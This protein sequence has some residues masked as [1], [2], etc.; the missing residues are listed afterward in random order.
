MGYNEGFRDYDNNQST[1][2]PNEIITQDI[3]Y[4]LKEI[5][6]KTAVYNIEVSPNDGGKLIRS[7]GSSANIVRKEAGKVT[8]MLPSKKEKTF[9]ENCR[10]TIGVVAGGGKSEKPVMKAGKKYFGIGESDNG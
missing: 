10:A 8:L 6:T 7:A 5:P 1:N 9:D 2:Q 3:I 4:Q